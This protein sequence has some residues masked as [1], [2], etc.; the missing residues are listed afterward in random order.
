[1]GITGWFITAALF[2]GF[3]P[4]CI[5]GYYGISKTLNL[6]E[7]NMADTLLTRT[8]WQVN[9]I[10]E[11]LNMVM[12]D[13]VGLAELPSLTSYLGGRTSMKSDLENDFLEFNKANTDYC[14]TRFVDLSGQEVIRSNNKNHKFFLTSNSELQ[15]LGNDEYF[16]KG[17]ELT[18]GDIYISPIDNNKKDN[19]LQQMVIRL[20]TPVYL[21][22]NKKGMLIVDLF[23]S[24]FFK[25]V[26]L[27]KTPF[28]SMLIDPEGQILYVQKNG[29]ELPFEGTLEKGQFVNEVF[30][31]LENDKLLSIGDDLIKT[32]W[33]KMVVRPVR[34]ANL[35]NP[36][37]FIATFFASSYFNSYLHNLKTY[38]LVSLCLVAVAGIIVAVLISKRFTKSIRN[39]YTGADLIAGGNYHQN[40]QMAT[41]DE[42]EDL[43]E[44][45]NRMRTQIKERYSQVLDSNKE[46]STELD[47][48]KLEVR[49]LQEQLFRADKLAAVGELSMKLAHE[50]GNPLASLKTVTQMMAERYLENPSQAQN[51]NKIVSEV[52]RLNIF[53][54]KFNNFAVMKEIEPVS[55]DLT[56]L[57]TD[58]NFFMKVQAR[59]GNIKLEETFEEGPMNIF[60]DLQQMKQVLVN[61]TLN[62]IQ[63]TS[64][65]GEIKVSLKNGNGKDCLCEIRESCFCRNKGIDISGNGMIELSVCDTGKGIAE[66]DIRKIFD[67]FFSTKSD[68]TGLGLSIVHKIVEKHKGMIRVFSKE[69][70]GTT[71]RV[72]LPKHTTERKV[73]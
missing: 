70:E 8:H 47:W 21:E 69:G 14:F 68:G 27:P 2:M 32:D 35:G 72:Y 9:R 25:W 10:E 6:L 31:F 33:G 38:L 66:K 49:N 53:L 45:F 11:N 26:E 12:S 5:F 48:H 3:V 29:N 46:L 19:D 61:L 39:L 36:Q 41:G 63:A 20:L 17:S 73:L 54:K 7:E 34:V 60:G 67:P 71:F 57:V 30:H 56:Q 4:I 64:G 18:K 1:M 40:I 55:C 58:V 22:D 16:Q 42:F 13:L 37:W 51:L 23:A 62:A 24:R 50:I 52:D 28:S 65:P 59:E 43:A 15:F 44:K